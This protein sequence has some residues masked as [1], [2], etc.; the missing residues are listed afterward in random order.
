MKYNIL[1]RDFYN[2]DKIDFIIEI[3]YIIIIVINTERYNK[4]KLK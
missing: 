3:I 2:F 4:S 1:N